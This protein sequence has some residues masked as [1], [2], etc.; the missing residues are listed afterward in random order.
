ME[1]L[2]NVSTPGVGN[3]GTLVYSTSDVSLTRPDRCA[4][5]VTRER[6]GL[7]QGRWERTPFLAPNRSWWSVYGTVPGFEESVTSSYLSLR[8]DLIPWEIPQTGRTW[9]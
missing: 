4:P 3:F 6:V 9:T 7:C 8:R 1:R 5:S 2:L